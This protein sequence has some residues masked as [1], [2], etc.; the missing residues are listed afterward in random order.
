[1]KLIEEDKLLQVESECKPCPEIP[2]A[3]IELPGL[4]EVFHI[5]MG[6]MG[7]IRDE[8]PEFGMKEMIQAVDYMR[9]TRK[10]P[11]LFSYLFL[12]GLGYLLDVCVEE[13]SDV[14]VPLKNCFHKLQ[15][16]LSAHT[17]PIVLY[18]YMKLMDTYLQSSVFDT[19]S[20]VSPDKKYTV[21]LGKENGILHRAHKHLIENE[22]DDMPIE[23]VVVLLKALYNDIMETRHVKLEIDK[24]VEESFELAKNQKTA[25]YLFRKTKAGYQVSQRQIEAQKE[26]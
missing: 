4:F 13:E 5:C 19:D 6:D 12:E 25:E 17:W 15:S 22:L 2:N 26:A 14:C 9:E 1:M 16:H 10:L 24:R 23:G 3:M 18:H 21:Y 7:S 11:I 8:L 20:C